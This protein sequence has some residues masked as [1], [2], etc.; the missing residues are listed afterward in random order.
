MSQ[1][2]SDQKAHSHPYIIYFSEQNMRSF[3]S[4]WVHPFECCMFIDK[5]Q[6][7]RSERDSDENRFLM[8]ISISIECVAV[9][10]H[11][12]IGFWYLLSDFFT[13][14]VSNGMLCHFIDISID[15]IRF[16]FSVWILNKPWEFL[17]SFLHVL[18]H[19]I[20]KPFMRKYCWISANRIAFVA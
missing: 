9:R 14:L 3:F 13:S 18:N 6:T 17:M 20:C 16:R 8:K 15:Y 11:L 7:Q 5:I 2:F 10:I 19:V 12:N 1:Y 4:S